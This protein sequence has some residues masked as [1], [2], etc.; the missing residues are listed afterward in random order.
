MWDVEPDGLG[1]TLGCVIN[2][3]Y[4]PGKL[5]YFL[6]ARFFSSVKYGL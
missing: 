4:G 5:L 6:K 2:L 1:S 3:L